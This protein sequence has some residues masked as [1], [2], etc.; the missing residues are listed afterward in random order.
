MSAPTVSISETSHRILQ[1]LAEQTG[2]TMT[3]VLDKALDA[4]RRKVFFEQLQAD[5]AALR[6]DPEAWAEELAERKLWEATLMDGLDPDERCTDDGRC[7][8]PETPT[9]ETA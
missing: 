6:A 5:Y 1:E 9:G 8:N 2:Q 4:Y 3:E 7:R